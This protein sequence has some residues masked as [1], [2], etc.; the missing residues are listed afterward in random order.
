VSAETAK[1]IWKIGTLVYTG[2]GLAALFFWLLLGDFAWAMRERSVGPMTQWYLSH[3]G[4]PS[5]VMGLLMTSLPSVV[6]LVLGPVIS[7]KSDRF[8]S[9]WGRRIPFLLVTTPV[10]AGSMIGL[11]LTPVLAGWL[12]ARFPGLSPQ[13]MALIG[14]GV[15]WAAFEVA[16][17]ASQAVFG[18]LINDVVPRELLGRFYG[19]FR[20]ISLMDAVVFN[21]WIM[22]LVPTHYTVIFVVLGGGYGILFMWVCLKVKEG[23]Y[24]P[25]E[26]IEAVGSGPLASFRG[27][28]R[29]YARECFCKA[30]YVRIFFMSML[31]GMSFVPINTFSIPFAESLGIDMDTYGKYLAKTFIVS[32]G[33]SFLLG[34]LAD[35]FHPL[36]MAMACLVC[37]FAVSIWGGFFATTAD[38]FLWA[39]VLHVVVSGSFFTSAASL[40]QRLYPR[41]K[42]AQFAS[43]SGIVGS[44]GGIVIGPLIGSVIDLT[45]RTYRFTFVG[46]A[47]L[48]L[49]ALVLSGFVYRDFMRLGGPEGYS[50]P[51]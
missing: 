49:A 44:L 35:K 34:W 26:P 39:W 4:V 38:T 1:K 16:A 51:D 10:A 14:V 48:A 18:A 11:G 27:A 50:P 42:F 24:P 33:L 20:A 37:Y 29:T 3:L 6:S 46:G 45:G 5:I 12:H 9:R 36:R 30:Y 25:P 7:F 2:G 19:L 15:F 41:V 17:I 31:A 21:Y 13:T 40:G 43:A 32:F 28:V 8:R 22:G 23:E 47:V